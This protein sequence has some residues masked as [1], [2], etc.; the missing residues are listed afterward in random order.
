M[1]I[2]GVS[3]GHKELGL[4]QVRGLSLSGLVIG[5]IVP[6]VGIMLSVGF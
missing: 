3:I 5:H 1:L 6:S 2:I 4:Y